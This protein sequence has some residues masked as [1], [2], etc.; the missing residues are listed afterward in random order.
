MSCH[1]NRLLG[2]ALVSALGASCA[3]CLVKDTKS[4]VCLEVD[5]TVTWSIVESGVRSENEDADQARRE[6]AEYLGDNAA[7]WG[8][9]AAAL[10]QIGGENVRS[11]LVRDRVP[12]E[13]RATATFAS[14]DAMIGAYCSS[15][16]WRC[17]SQTARLGDAATWTWAATEVAGAEGDPV[18]PLDEAVAGLRIVLAQGRFLA[19]EGFELVDD[20]SAVLA[21]PKGEEE[22]PLRVSLT[23][24]APG[25]HER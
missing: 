21:I 8:P 4:T 1:S 2:F 9:L 12:Y 19:A 24:R 16:G 15:A 5:G 13:V 20:R 11:V 25:R 14:L 22:Q 7:G 6:E 3:A 10:A 17:D 23:W 18:D